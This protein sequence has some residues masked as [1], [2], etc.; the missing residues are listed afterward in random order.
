M[1][2]L[3]FRLPLRRSRRLRLGIWDCPTVSPTRIRSWKLHAVVAYFL[4]K[5]GHVGYVDMSRLKIM[6]AHSKLIFSLSNH[7]VRYIYAFFPEFKVSS[8][9]SA[10]HLQAT[11][12]DAKLNGLCREHS[13][14]IAYRVPCD[15]A[16]FL[17][18][19]FSISAS[20]T[21]SFWTVSAMDNAYGGA[22][23]GN[24]YG[25]HQNRASPS[26]FVE[27]DYGQQQHAWGSTESLPQGAREQK[28]DLK[29]RP[30]I[31]I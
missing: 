27:G 12:T 23:G 30:D 4:G 17:V 31:I 8:A 14:Q 20:P 18:L 10:F 26:N 3:S 2:S 1:T 11:E 21:H 28:S 6:S 9:Q 5:M 25:D 19:R 29:A 16:G 24:V 15:R 22:Y 13:C 7:Q